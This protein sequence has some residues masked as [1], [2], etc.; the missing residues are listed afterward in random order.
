MPHPKERER[1]N[2]RE[3]WNKEERVGRWHFRSSYGYVALRKVPVVGRAQF[4]R[5]DGSLRETVNGFLRGMMQ[6]CA[7]TQTETRVVVCLEIGH[8]LVELLREVLIMKKTRGHFFPLSFS[9]KTVFCQA[10]CFV[11]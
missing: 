8:C 11:I 10:G 7:D 6:I 9:C 4:E 2:R 5:L 3:G 1:E